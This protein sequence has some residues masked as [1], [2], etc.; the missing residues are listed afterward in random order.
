MSGSP[1]VPGRGAGAGGRDVECHHLHQVMRRGTIE[2]PRSK[3]QHFNPRFE[4]DRR[5]ENQ[6]E[7][8]RKS[9]IYFLMNEDER[10][11]EIGMTR[12][13]SSRLAQRHGTLG[14]V[15]RLLAVIDGDL[16]EAAAIHE[17][18]A[19]LKVFDD[20]Y[21]IDSTMVEF[22]KREGHPWSDSMLTGTPAYD[23]RLADLAEVSK[24]PAATLMELALSGWADRNGFST[25][26]AGHNLEMMNR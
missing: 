6:R 7:Q 25:V 4:T 18:F 26:P 16:P 9:M 17:R 12:H 23:D 3:T 20:W 24:I 21:R 22:I 8:A 2:G 5:S 13:M 14:N 15:L 11:I 1:K 19:H 10:L